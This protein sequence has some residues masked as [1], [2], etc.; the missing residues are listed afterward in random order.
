[1]YKFLVMLPLNNIFITRHFYFR[2]SYA[3][4][5]LDHIMLR[6]MDVKYAHKLFYICAYYFNLQ[7]YEHTK[8]L[9]N[10]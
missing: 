7:C 2:F 8:V 6:H 9:E 10:V 5:T 3:I 4:F 1:M